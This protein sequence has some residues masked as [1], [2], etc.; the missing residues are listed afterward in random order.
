MFWFPLLPTPTSW[1]RH[2][3]TS[4]SPPLLLATSNTTSTGDE[5]QVTD[6]PPPLPL[7]EPLLQFQHSPP[8]DSTTQT[9]DDSPGLAGVDIAQYEGVP[10]K[11]E[12][13]STS[14]NPCEADSSCSGPSGATSGG[15][16]VASTAGPLSIPPASTMIMDGLDTLTPGQT[17][18]HHHHPTPAPTAAA[19]FVT[20]AAVAAAAAHH[21]NV[22]SFEY[23]ESSAFGVS[24]GE[25]GGDQGDRRP[26]SG[27][28]A[29]A[30][31]AATTARGED[32]AAAPE[33]Q[34]GDLNTPVTTSGDIP[35][36][37]GP[38]TVVEPPPITGKTH[39]FYRLMCQLVCG[40]AAKTCLNLAIHHGS[41]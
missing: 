32:E 29:S 9:E 6:T 7:L 12:P 38:S 25:T 16:A 20:E 27:G 3:F 23:K 36:F 31:A 5:D 13:G 8:A 17:H 10:I 37:F 19:F 21:I 15:L 40:A 34:P 14:S 26:G 41:F 18:H 30:G 22:L 2:I 39:V 11:V 28:S 1:T 4:S 35:S 24:G 33:T